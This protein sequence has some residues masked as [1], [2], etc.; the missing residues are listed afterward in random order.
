LEKLD[1]KLD[2]KLNQQNSGD[3][4]H[5]GKYVEREVGDYANSRNTIKRILECTTH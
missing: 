1:K 5:L 4:S 2:E 3:P